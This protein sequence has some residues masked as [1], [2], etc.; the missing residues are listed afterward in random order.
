MLR[1]TNNGL[2]RYKEMVYKEF[3]IMLNND[4]MPDDYDRKPDTREIAKV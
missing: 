3:G 1:K 2:K 4:E